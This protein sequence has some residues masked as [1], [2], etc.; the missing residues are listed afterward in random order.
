MEKYLDWFTQKIFGFVREFFRRLFFIEKNCAHLKTYLED[1]FS[2]K[3]FELE[4]HGKKTKHEN[5]NQKPWI[6]DFRYCSSLT[7]FYGKRFVFVR[8][9]FRRLF[10]IE[11]NCALM[12]TYR[13]D[14]F[15]RKGFE[16]EKHGKKTKQ[17]N[18]NQKPWILDFGQ[19][20]SLTKFIR[21]NIW[22]GFHRKIGI[23]ER[24]CPTIIFHGKTLLRARAFLESFFQ[25]KK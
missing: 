16:L 8:E 5:V 20:S 23:R 15:S 21:E 24:A 10:F 13:K 3:G 14:H 1:H 17:E 7:K 18:G 6:L 12:K 2:R 4:K 19:F 25:G 22:I 9:F 11:K